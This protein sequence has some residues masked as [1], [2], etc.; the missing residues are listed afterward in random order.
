M[1]PL[2][3]LLVVAALAPA[4]SITAPTPPPQPIVGGEP[5]ADGEWLS[6]VAIVGINTGIGVDEA[7]ICTGVLLDTKTALTA[8]HCLEE[9]S[10]FD[11][12]LVIF[13]GSLYTT[14]DRLRTAGVDFGTHPDYCFGECDQDVHDFGYVVLADEAVGVPLI[15][16]LVDQAEWDEVM[17]VD[18]E[19]LIVGFG[20][21][22][23]PDDGGALQMDEV[24]HKESVTTKITGFS[25]L[26]TEFIAGEPNRDTCGGDS[27]GP[28]FAQLSDGSW[29]L[30]GI[31]SR[32][33]SPC[34][35]GRGI[36][37]VPF[38]ALPWIREATGIDLLPEGCA[39]GECLDTTPPKTRGGG[40]SIAAPSTPLDL[41]LLILLAAATG[42]RGRLRV[43]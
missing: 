32:G 30:I 25:H 13:G 3:H 19:V 35:T 40:C 5:V 1:P 6:A 15:P 41:G 14:D 10:T 18:H 11:S 22:R 33:V 36:Y 20:A 42:R 29:R 17:K 28:V 9:A 21:I 27:G 4:G 37:G 24:G 23:D 8:A 2:A 7:H 16:P 43:A 39:D 12:L 26:G 31:T 34:G 38:A